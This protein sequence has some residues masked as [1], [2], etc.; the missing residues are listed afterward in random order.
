MRHAH[1]H[2]EVCPGEYGRPMLFH[3]MD[4]QLHE[5]LHLSELGLPKTFWKYGIL[6]NASDDAR[7]AVADKCAFWKHPIDC[8]RKDDNRQRQQKWFSGEKW[9]TFCAGERGSPGGPVAIATLVLIVADDMQ[10]RGVT[11]GACELDAPLPAVATAAAAPTK[12]APKKKKARG[13]AAFAA[14]AATSEVAPCGTPQVAE[15]VE[16][17]EHRPTALE[18]EC[19]PEDL[20]IIRELFGSRAQTILNALLSADG[21]FQWYYPYKA[22]IPFMCPIPLREERALDNACKAIRMHEV[23]ERVSIRA[24]GSY[25]SHLAI[26]KVSRDILRLGCVWAMGSSPLELQNAE[27]KRVA[28]SGGS[29]AL[30]TRDAGLQ[31]RP[32]RGVSEGPAQLVATRGNSTSMAISTLKNMLATSYLRRGDGIVATPATRRKERLFGKTGNGRSSLTSHGIKLENLGAEYDPR[33]DTCVKAF[34]RLLAARATAD[35]AAEDLL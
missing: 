12:A 5:P 13:K 9:G 19:D 8:R 35:K 15:P 28:S 2:G 31:R 6:N 11:C 10:A 21:Y 32:M 29:R 25:L 18:R 27:T 17:L 20:A 4:D 23:F 24:H 7:D 30:T 34:V 22:S 14:R 26:F 1:A 3:D 33:A 16:T